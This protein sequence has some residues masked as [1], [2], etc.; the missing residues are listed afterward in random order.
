MYL[1]ILLSDQI[2]FPLFEVF[3]LLVFLYAIVK[4]HRWFMKSTSVVL[5]VKRGEKT[6]NY[7]NLAYGIASVV[8]MQV[9]NVSEALKGYKT[10]ISLANLLILFYLAFFNSWF[11]NKII[12]III[13]SQEKKER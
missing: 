8:L 4:E 12:G 13:K 11:R 9:I 5:S 3:L 7:F 2:I 1:D 10:I 6:W